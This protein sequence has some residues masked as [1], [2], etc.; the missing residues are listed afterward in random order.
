MTFD[1]NILVTIESGR[2]CVLVTVVHVSQSA[3]RELS[4]KML[5]LPDKS[6]KGTIG[7]G[8]LEQLAIEDALSAL[9][10]KESC[11]I[12]YPLGEKTQQCC[13]GL[14]EL[15]F[16]PLNVGPQLFIYGAGHVGEAIA[17]VMS[18]TPYT[19]HLIDQ[20]TEFPK[21]TK[22][23]Q[24][25]IVHHQDPVHFIDN[26]IVGENQYHVI[27]THSHDLDLEILAKLIHKESAYLGLIGSATKWKRFQ[28]KLLL[29]G[30]SAFDGRHV[31][32]PIGIKF[33][34]KAPKEVAI[35][36]ATELL[37]IHYGDSIEL[38]NYNFSSGTIKPH[39]STQ[40]STEF[41]RQTLDHPSA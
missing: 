13:G 20:R 4:A 6:I 17:E 38:S 8:R 32:C 15:F 2:P 25:V 11:K 18:G 1:R 39:A 10:K 37:C 27:L 29:R 21:S 30:I 24:D 7:G 31:R 33:S 35:G 34:G 19:T 22:L 36:L 9:T 41:S 3:P 23:P 12:S 26:L 14:V 28:R 16:E 40:A 5:V